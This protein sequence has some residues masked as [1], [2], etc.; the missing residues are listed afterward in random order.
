MQNHCAVPNCT[1]GKSDPQPLFRFPHDPERSKKWAEKCQKQDLIDKSPGQLYRYYRICGKHF[2][3]S[4]V[5]SN[6]QSTVLKDDAIPTIFDV[7]IQ[8]QNGPVKRSKET[9]GQIYT[10]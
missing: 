5:D 1:S 8:P 2:E 6:A 3:T 9:V 4:L 10:S 7:P